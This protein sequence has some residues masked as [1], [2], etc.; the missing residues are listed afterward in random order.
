LLLVPIVIGVLL[1]PAA[2]PDAA[3]PPAA[4]TPDFRLSTSPD[5]LVVRRGETGRVTV[6]VEPVAGFKGGVELLSSLLYATDTVFSP[7]SIP[8][9]GGTSVLAISPSATAIKGKYTLSITATSDGI[10]HSI[11]VAVTVK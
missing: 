7:P 3:Q 4:R 6:K 10:S 9:G 5:T 8:D 1:S 11:T 2:R